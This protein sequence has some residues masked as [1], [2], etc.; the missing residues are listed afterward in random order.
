MTVLIVLVGLLLSHHFTAVGRWRDFRWLFWPASWLHSHFPRKAWLMLA[1]VIATAV[2]T[3]WLA[4][5]AAVFFLGGFGWALLALATLVYTLG[6]RD[7]DRDIHLIIEQPEHADGREAARAL[8]LTPET[9]P[10]AG[11]AAVVHAARRRW[12]AVL[13]WFTLLGIPGALLY[14]LSEKAMRTDG[15]SEDELDGLARLRWILEWPVLVLMTISLGLVTDL[16]R[17]VQ[18]WK[19]YHRDRAW[20]IVSPRLIDDVMGSVLVDETSL[21]TGLRRGHQLAWR[22]LVLWLVIMS[23]MLIAG[24]LV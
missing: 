11:G 17:V 24:W 12:F 8:E 18:A 10:Q 5:A 19:T 20:W 9:H 21:E 7:L 2:V 16:D 1:A 23:V 15:L 3:A 6:P 13:F 22:M 4:T 14:R